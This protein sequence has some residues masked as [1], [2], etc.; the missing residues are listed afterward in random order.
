MHPDGAST[1]DSNPAPHTKLGSEPPT[2]NSVA[3]AILLIALGEGFVDLKIGECS[4]LWVLS[5]LYCMWHVV[6]VH[7]LVTVGWKDSY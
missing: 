1:E 7:P 3:S 4:P 5:L 6:H 2:T